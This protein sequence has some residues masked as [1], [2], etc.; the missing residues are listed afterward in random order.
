[1]HQFKCVLGGVPCWPQQVMI[2]QTVPMQTHL[3]VSTARPKKK[4]RN[5]F[6]LL[7]LLE[8]EVTWPFFLF[9][10]HFLFLP[11]TP[12]HL[13][14]VRVTV[15]KNDELASIATEAMVGLVHKIALAS[16][17]QLEQ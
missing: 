15:N 13:L 5:I 7:L 4:V 17:E 11:K 1:M 2:A 10:H 12:P 14:P 6:L 8:L 3:T 16:S 9:F